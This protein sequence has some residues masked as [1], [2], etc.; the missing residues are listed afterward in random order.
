MVSLYTPDISQRSHLKGIG[1][2]HYREAVVGIAA[3][4]GEFGEMVGGVE[5]ACPVGRCKRMGNSV[6]PVQGF[7]EEGGDIVSLKGKEGRIS[8][9][10]AL[11]AFHE[12][13]DSREVVID[14]VGGEV[15]E[16][17]TV[18]VLRFD[19]LHPGEFLHPDKDDRVFI[20]KPGE[21]V[22][23]NAD[24]YLVVIGHHQDVWFVGS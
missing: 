6:L 3:K 19:A 4:I 2:L 9:E 16:V 15:T 18:Q 14:K 21:T 10:F 8:T 20:C 7:K 17:D 22:H 12:S 24:T 11:E 23:G 13:G 5:Q 1:I